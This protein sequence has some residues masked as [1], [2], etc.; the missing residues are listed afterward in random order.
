MAD[1]ARHWLFKS[2]PDAY[3]LD[4][5][6]RDRRTSWEGVRNFQ[7]RDFLRAMRLGDLGFFYHSSTEVPAAVGIV[8]VVRTA[9]PDPTARDPKSDYYDARASDEKPYWS[10]VEVAFVRRLPR[11]VTLAEIRAT[12]SL[13]QMLLVRRSRLSVSPVGEGEWETILRMSGI[14]HPE[15][16]R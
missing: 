14:D 12:P 11:A 1:V 10:T 13:A 5:L 3:G 4:H 9:F 2:E 6:E 15:R 7:A 16:V 8:E